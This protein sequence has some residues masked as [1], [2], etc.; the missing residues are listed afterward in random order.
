MANISVCKEDA[1][2]F[3]LTVITWCGTNRPSYTGGAYS[4]H[5][6]TVLRA[7]SIYI[8]YR[9]LCQEILCSRALVLAT[10]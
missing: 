7:V 3:I 5:T 10:C 9:V 1:H 2:L 6:G 4:P 8:L